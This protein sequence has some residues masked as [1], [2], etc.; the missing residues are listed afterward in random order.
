M[1]SKLNPPEVIQAKCVGCGLCLQ[2]CPSFVLDVTQGKARVARGDWCIECGHCGAICPVEAIS[3]KGTLSDSHPRS[4]TQAASSPEVLELL[5]RERRSIRVYEKESI[6]D[7]ILE[8]ILDA[9]RYAPTGTNSQNVHYVALKSSEEI[10]R[11]RLMT[12]DFY[13][14]IFARIQ[15]WLGALLLRL[16]AGRRLVDSLRDSLPKVEFAKKLMEKGQDCLFYHAPVVVVAHAE[17]WDT[18]SPFNCSV[19]LYN[20]SLVAHTLGI[21]CCFNGYLVSAINSDRKI[22]R[23]LAI[24]PDHKCYAAMTLGYQK[25]RYP[26]LVKREPAKVTWR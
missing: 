9:G 6:P 13:A 20:C 7:D 4:W 19:A 16:F 11:L 1:K 25:L 15:G 10:E 2:V 24:P 8:R 22:K 26:R 5:F 3:Q 17:S 18:C 21:G 23:W 12:T 14:K